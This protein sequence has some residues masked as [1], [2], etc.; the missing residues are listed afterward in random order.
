MECIK[1]SN[2]RQF[3]IDRKVELLEAYEYRKI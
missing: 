2:I 1:S 3:S